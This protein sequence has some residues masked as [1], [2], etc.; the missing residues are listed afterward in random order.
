MKIRAYK[1]PIN[2]FEFGVSVFNMS[3]HVGIYIDLIFFCF[4]F[5][6]KKKGY[7]HDQSKYN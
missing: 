2:V 5:E 3:E 7:G 6:F 1:S 4:M